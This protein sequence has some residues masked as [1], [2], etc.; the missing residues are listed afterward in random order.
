MYLVLQKKCKPYRRSPG[1]IVVTNLKSSAK[2]TRSAPFIG[3]RIFSPLPKPTTPVLNPIAPLLRRPSTRSGRSGNFASAQSMNGGSKQQRK[4]KREHHRH[5]K[6]PRK[7]KRGKTEDDKYF[8]REIRATP[9]WSEQGTRF[10][11]RRFRLQGFQAL[12]VLH[13][14]I[15][16]PVTSL[17][18]IARDS[19]IQIR[20]EKK[21]AGTCAPAALPCCVLRS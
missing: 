4:Q 6:F 9:S 13:P 10:D 11:R 20:R 21:T 14:F 3:P 17:A 18:V 2:A 12:L 16:Q 15:F 19:P 8:R 7:I 1:G 5:K